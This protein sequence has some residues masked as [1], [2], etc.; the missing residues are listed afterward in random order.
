MALISITCT[1]RQP[2]P[3]HTG[4][5]RRCQHIQDGVRCIAVLSDYNPGPVCGCHEEAHFPHLGIP[6][7]PKRAA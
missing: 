3:F 5:V 1:E 4:Q 7:R 6:I 2:G